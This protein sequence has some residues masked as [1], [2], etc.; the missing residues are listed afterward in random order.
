MWD[1]V[2]DLEIWETIAQEAHARHSRQTGTYVRLLT[3]VE[4]YAHR[5]IADSARGTR[6]V[7]EIGIGGGEHLV[8]R[9][10]DT[11][12]E[13]YVGLDLSPEYA[14]ICRQ[15]FGV[16]VVC[17]DAADM[18]FENASFDCVLANSILEH[19]EQ[20]DRVLDEVERVLA[21]GGRFLV[22]VPTNGSLAVGTFKTL[23]TYPTMRRRGIK[24]PD[25][26]W[27][28]LNV[29]NFKRVQSQVLRRFP[30]ARQ[31]AVP[32]RLLPWQLS[33]LWAF[34]CEKAR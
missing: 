27:N 24:R 11:G 7:L 22:I 28:H 32:V 25:L 1:A 13:R 3:N 12:T 34:L 15:K 31:V 23:M 2:R 26:V 8:Y 20:L 19:V 6:R 16:E 14:E 18:P 30:T 4:D 33:P 9:H 17:A 5:L 10:P 29:N 21:P